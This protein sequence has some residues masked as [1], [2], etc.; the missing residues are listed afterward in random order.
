MAATS[1]RVFTPFS[2]VRTNFS[3]FFLLSCHTQTQKCIQPLLVPS[4]VFMNKRWA[5]HAKRKPT[6]F[7][8]EDLITRNE[9]LMKKLN[10][11]DERLMSKDTPTDHGFHVDSTGKIFSSFIPKKDKSPK[12]LWESTKAKLMSTYAIAMIK[13]K[14]SRP[15]KVVEFAQEAQK[16]FIDLNNDLQLKRNKAI[17]L[18]M[19]ENATLEVLFALQKQFDVPGKKVYWRFVKQLE[20]PRIVNCAASHVP[21]DKSNIY[22]QVTVRMCTEQIL[23]IRDRYDRLIV[24]SLKKPKKVVDFVVFE[25][26]LSNPYGNWRICGKINA[27]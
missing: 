8:Q 23:A 21:E 12:Y 1:L 9:E 15:F 7:P 25:R 4:V 2:Y 27:I 6:K 22:A 11:I 17:E 19:E 20:R 14:E 3:N 26:H 5:S 13:R 10:P 16:K 18:R 24:G